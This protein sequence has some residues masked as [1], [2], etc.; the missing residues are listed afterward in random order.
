MALSLEKLSLLVLSHLLAALLDHTT[1][2]VSPCAEITARLAPIAGAGLFLESC[3]RPVKPNGFSRLDARDAFNHGR[4]LRKG[5]P[6]RGA[7]LAAVLH[8]RQAGENETT[9]RAE[10]PI[11][12]VS[13]RQERNHGQSSFPQLVDRLTD[14][15]MTR[16]DHLPS[17]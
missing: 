7:N 12:D 6:P 14:S 9:S 4:E 13:A 1:Q 3:Q 8:S 5:A 2:S 10:R 15:F 11:H 17:P 16:I